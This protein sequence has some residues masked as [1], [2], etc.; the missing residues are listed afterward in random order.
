[1]YPNI[2][3]FGETIETLINLKFLAGTISTVKPKESENIFPENKIDANSTHEVG[4]FS[5][6]LDAIN[7]LEELELAGLNLSRVKLIA[8]DGWRCH[9]LSDLAICDRFEDKLF[10]CDRTAHDFF[11]QLFEQGK[12]LLVFTGTQPEL[13]FINAIIDP[14]HG[15]LGVWY[16]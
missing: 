12:Y 9:W 15:R 13:S 1:M 4:V 16:F 3:Q 5:E 11:R 8:S 6:Y 10:D 7:V 2:Y 14:H